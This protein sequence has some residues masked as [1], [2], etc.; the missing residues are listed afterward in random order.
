MG[1]SS[2][3]QCTPAR[4][5]CKALTLGDWGWGICCSYHSQHKGRLKHKGSSLHPF[6]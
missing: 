3:P 6:R 2:E 4:V 1:K 5:S